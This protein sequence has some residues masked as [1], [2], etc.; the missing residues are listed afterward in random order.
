MYFMKMIDR[1]QE[2]YD[3]PRSLDAFVEIFPSL[4]CDM[5][6]CGGNVKSPTNFEGI[7]K[8]CEY[9]IVNAQKK[10]WRE[11]DRELLKEI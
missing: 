8:K 4:Q 3:C 9:Y 7:C 10:D 2:R 11:V 1:T 6:A 5:R